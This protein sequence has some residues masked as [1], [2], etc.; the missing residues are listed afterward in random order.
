MTYSIE[1]STVLSAE[2]Q[3]ITIEFAPEL[4]P[5]ETEYTY[6][7]P[8]FVFG[9]RVFPIDSFPED[10]YI[11][12]GL[13]LIES[14]TP[15]GKLLNQPRWKYKISNGEV[16]YCKDERA[17]V[18][19]KN[20]QAKTICANCQH[21]ENFHERERGWCHLFKHQAKTFHRQTNDCLL[22]SQAEEMA[23]LKIEDELDSTRSPYKVGSIVKVIDPAEDHI[24]WAVF[25]VVE[26]KYNPT[27]Y[28]NTESYLNEP[29]WYYRLVSNVDAS[30]IS[31]SLWVREDEIC[32]FDIS[33]L[34]S[35]DDI[36]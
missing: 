18:R 23:M 20:Q 12:C 32:H 9:D 16:S 26:C 35:T 3:L 11:V 10:E 15:S 8:Q 34:I 1:N 33:H 13:E 30:T 2:R 4:D 31:K 19:C 6:L 5:N 29:Q 24:D 25:E 7:H 21:F 36:F 17:L 28:R 22:N 14:K 27:L